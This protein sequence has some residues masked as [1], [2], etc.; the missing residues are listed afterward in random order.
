[1]TIVASGNT[2]SLGGTTTVSG[3]NQSIEYELKTTYGTTGSNTIS[4]NDSA[5]R[6]LAGIGS[7]AISFASLYGKS[8]FAPLLHAYTTGSGTETIPTGATN[9]TIEVWGGGGGGGG[10]NT[11]V[12]FGD[13]GG[14]GAYT[15]ALFAVS[16]HAGQTIAYSVGA[17]GAGGVSST[18]AGSAGGNSTAS[19]GTFT[20]ST[21]TARGGAGGAMQGGGSGSGTGG[22]YTNANPGATGS[23]GITPTGRLGSTGISGSISGDGSPHGGSGSGGTNGSGGAGT[24]GA[25]VFYYT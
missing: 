7:G 20:L 6:T 2:I 12:N 3:A 1:M 10:G 24:P 14:T 17:Q 23:T 16:T 25:V 9:L 18:G 4:L 19:T 5:V 21:I 8:S 22:T 13:A 15:T 11:S